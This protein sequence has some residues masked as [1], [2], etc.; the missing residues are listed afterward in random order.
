MRTN[1]CHRETCEGE[2]EGEKSLCVCVRKIEAVREREKGDEKDCA[3]GCEIMKQ[4][5]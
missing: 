1:V 4:N 3:S 5:V 2:K